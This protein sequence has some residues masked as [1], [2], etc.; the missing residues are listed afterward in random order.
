MNG[1]IKIA[2]LSALMASG[3]VLANEDPTQTQQPTDPAATAPQATDTQW[4]EFS[5]LDTNGDGY[6][7]REEARSNATLSGSFSDLDADKNGSLS[8][9][10]YQKGKEM[11]S[12][13]GTPDSSTPSETPSETQDPSTT[14]PTAPPQQ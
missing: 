5:T 6:V 10:E 9:S 2:A 4:P 14:E 3:A 12:Q 7:S 1:M 11:Q 13:S 8:S